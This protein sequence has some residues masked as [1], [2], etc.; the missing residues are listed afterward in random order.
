MK[1]CD[2]KKNNKINISFV[3]TI[4]TVLILVL[5]LLF[6]LTGCNQLNINNSGLKDC[7]Q[8]LDNKEND[9]SQSD[10]LSNKPYSN[11]PLQDINKEKIADNE[12][13]ISVTN[14]EQTS[15]TTSDRENSLNINDLDDEYLKEILKDTKKETT[16]PSMN[17]QIVEGPV[18][19]DDNSICYYRVK[20]NVRGYPKPSLVF[21]K[22]DSLGSWGPYF[23]QINLAPGET[24]ELVAKATNKVGESVISII[25]TW[26]DAKVNLNTKNIF[27]EEKKPGNYLVEVS[28]SEQK[29]RVFYK[30]NILKEMICS[31]GGPKTSTPTGVYKTSD[32]IFYSWLPKYNVGAYYFVRFFNS[33]LFHST[34]FD[35]DGNIISE[36]RLNIGKPVSHGC[37]RLDVEDAKWFYESIPSGVTVNIY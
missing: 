29:V 8:G 35:K 31:S 27:L 17:I 36:D 3:V 26:E 21:S 33:Y 25:F 20:A 7:S 9:V 16:P 2:N 19:L 1:N 13:E 6:T 11:Y 28:L 37:I 34:P 4:F 30:D 24:Y 15:S 22:D 32:K 14:E 5:A 12:D 18:I 23:A 10:S